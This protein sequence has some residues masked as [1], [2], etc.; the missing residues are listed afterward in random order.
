MTRK[1]VRENLSR[2][3]GEPC[4]YCEGRG[5]IRSTPSLCYEILRSIRREAMNSMGSKIIVLV[6]PDVATFL[7]DEERN[8]VEEL[9]K[10]IKKKI[11]I[12]IKDDLHHEQ[13]EIYSQ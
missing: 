8:G 13:F 2:K 7:Y 4:P 5:S 6:H 9:E 1:R 11:I 12:K 10:Q 3:M